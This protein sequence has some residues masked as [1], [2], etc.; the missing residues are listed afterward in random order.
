MSNETKNRMAFL[1]VS[2]NTQKESSQQAALRHVLEAWE[3]AIC[4]GIEPEKL[5]HATL[6]AALCE[7]VSV[8]GEEKTADIVR[9]LRKRVFNG[10][11]TIYRTLQ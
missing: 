5:A 2:K 11:F 6:Y 8:Y 7:F 1:E 3:D 4:E 9:D 10:E